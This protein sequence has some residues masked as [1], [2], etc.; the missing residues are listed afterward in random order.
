MAT[1]HF[2]YGKPG[3]GKTS[4]ARELAAS[5]PAV[6]FIEEEWLVLLCAPIT[7]L[8][9]YAEAARRVRAVIAPL[10]TR[11]LELGTS[12][13]FD[14]AANTSRERAWVRSISD[15]ARAEHILHV[16]DLP[17]DE[18]RRRVH[19]RNDAKPAGLYFGHVSDAI[20]D[21]VLPH[22]TLPTDAEG[23]TVV[24]HPIPKSL[25]DRD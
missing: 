17:D 3:A 4:L 9:E 16:L 21:A 10:A 12:V 22:I 20:F 19:A 14:F 2:V 18:C 11:I 5:M 15:A 8:A 13:V 6:P 24:F 1:L 7:T 25:L 23:F